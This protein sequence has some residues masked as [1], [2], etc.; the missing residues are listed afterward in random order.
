MITIKNIVQNPFQNNNT[1]DLSFIFYLYK[2]SGEDPKFFSTDP[3]LSQLIM[4]ILSGSSSG[5]K[6]FRQ[7][8]NLLILEKYSAKDENQII[9]PLLQVGSGS[10]RSTIT[11]SGS[12]PLYKMVTFNRKQVF[13]DDKFQIYDCR[14]SKSLLI[15]S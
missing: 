5:L 11:G 3:D 12:S 8:L 7:N 10:G 14:R 1:T 9:Y 15:S 4:E 2:I 13:F 6:M